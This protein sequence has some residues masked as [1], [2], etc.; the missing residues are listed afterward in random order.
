[1]TQPQVFT[2]TRTQTFESL[3]AGLQLSGIADRKFIALN[4]HI[5]NSVVVA[6]ELVILGDLST[7]SST[8]QEAYMMT[9]A[10]EVHIALLS[11]N[12]GA[13]DF[14][15]DNYELLKSMLAHG[16]L[17]AGVVSDAWS[18]HLEAIRKSLLN[19]E[20]LHNDYLRS[21]SSTARDRFFTE[22]AFLLGKLASQLDSV[23]AYGA[24]LQKDGTL[25]R[26]LGIST[27]SFMH[28]GEIDGYAAKINGVAKAAKIVK[29]GIYIGVALE[30]SSAALSIQKAC[31][32]GR[33]QECR[34]A[35]YVEG[36]SLAFGLGAG[37]IGATAG[38]YAA[39][40]GCVFVLGIATGGPG[41]LVCGVV[42]GAVGGWGGGEIGSIT[43]ERLGDFLYGKSFQ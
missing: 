9:K 12:I 21:G 34:K 3:R 1:M 23:A 30:V 31:L 16:S 27:K 17:G 33:E 39:V 25:K 18:R 40:L 5:A 15:L 37:A 10:N 7:P 35:K 26:M 42:G 11:N 38:G 2:N 24:G 36:S 19:I 4:G 6:G 29:R 8:S 22:R 13:D 32:L 20:K 41:A 28:K 43:G 14:L